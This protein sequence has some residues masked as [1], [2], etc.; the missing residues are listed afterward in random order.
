MLSSAC[1]EAVGIPS[2]PCRGADGGDGGECDDHAVKFE[3]GVG[4]ISFCRR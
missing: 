1:N 2:L 3:E 4:G